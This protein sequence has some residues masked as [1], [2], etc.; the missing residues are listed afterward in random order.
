MPAPSFENAIAFH[1]PT[2]EAPYKLVRVAAPPKHD[3]ELLCRSCGGPLRNREGKFALK[4]FRAD[5]SQA[6]PDRR[7]LIW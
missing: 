5:G 2:C 1:C 3:H 7:K 6:R 4:Y